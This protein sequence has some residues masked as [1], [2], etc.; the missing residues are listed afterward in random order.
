MAKNCPNPFQ[1]METASRIQEAAKDRRL[2]EEEID[3]FFKK[4]KEYIVTFKIHNGEAFLSLL[5][6]FVRAEN[7]PFQIDAST[8]NPDS[9]HPLAILARISQKTRAD[10]EIW[11]PFRTGMYSFIENDSTLDTMQKEHMKSL[12]DIA[13]TKAKNYADKSLH[14]LFP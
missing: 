14:F 6:F 2:S 4:L 9:A 5:Y 8:N 11:Q 10:E 7:W 3:F 13:I 12:T 1:L